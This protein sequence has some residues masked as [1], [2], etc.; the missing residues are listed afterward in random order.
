[1]PRLQR[2]FALVLSLFLSPWALKAE[3]VATLI[4]LEGTVQ[5]AAGF[6]LQAADL[7]QLFSAGDRLSTQ[8]ASSAHLVLPDG[9]SLIL[10]AN[11]ELMLKALGA[12]GAILQV[13]QGLIDFVGNPG[14]SLDLQTPSASLSAQGADFEVAVDAGSTQVT[15]NEG[16][17]TLSD[18]AHKRSIPVQALEQ[19]RLFGGRLERANALGK[20]DIDDFR[21]R[22]Q[23][24]HL[25][26]PQRF[27]LLK[28]FK[29]Q[30]KTER[31]KLKLRRAKAAL[32]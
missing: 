31:K 7:G 20:R 27:E 17:L 30:E 3:P 28:S 12:T 10:A 1:M 8:D 18:P 5:V 4:S 11:T 6:S 14:A 29:S 9:S 21:E 15:V 24:A 16:Q 2:V 25:I 19:A 23:R 22:W 26:H 13:R 32:P